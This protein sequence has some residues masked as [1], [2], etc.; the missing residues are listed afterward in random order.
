[1][2]TFHLMRTEDESGISGTGIVAE[3]V[4]FSSGKVCIAWVSG[5]VKSETI[6]DSIQEVE[7]IHGHGGKT[8][9]VFHTAVQDE[10]AKLFHAL[11]KL[12]RL[13]E[14]VMEAIQLGFQKAF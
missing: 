14:D 2:R 8:E 1:M 6:Y 10:L 9:L 3:G 5:V 12:D 13:P 11:A 4:E 7:K